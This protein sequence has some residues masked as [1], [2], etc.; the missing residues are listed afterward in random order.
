MTSLEREGGAVEG[1]GGTR[2]RASPFS[3][4]SGYGELSLIYLRLIKRPGSVPHYLAL[5]PPLPPLPP[6]SPPRPPPLPLLPPL[7]PPRLPL[8]LLRTDARRLGDWTGAAAGTSLHART[9]STRL[10]RDSVSDSR[11]LNLLLYL[12][13]VCRYATVCLLIPHRLYLAYHFSSSVCSGP[14]RRSG[15]LAVIEGKGEAKVVGQW[16]GWRVVVMGSCGHEVMY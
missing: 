13:T 15:R 7:P 8:P 9:G 16:A 2:G 12:M 10:P 4:Y 1:Q 6:L 3:F 11:V 5:P 14:L